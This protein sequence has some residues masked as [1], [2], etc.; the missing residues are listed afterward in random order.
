MTVLL[1][2]RHGST[3]AVGLRVSGRMP[4]VELNARGA[5]E[6]AALGA[7]LA[8]LPISVV[9]SSPIERAVATARAIA[10]PHRLE[11]ELRDGLSEIE[12]GEWTGLT[13][14]E[15]DQLPRWRAFNGFRAGTR[16]PAGEHMLEVQARMVREVERIVADHPTATVVLVSHGD[17]LKTLIG[18]F[19]G[20]PVDLWPRFDVSPASLSVLRVTTEGATLSL[21]NDSGASGATW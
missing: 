6:V 17:P 1:L 9:Y 21:L 11:V 10:T 18:H 12:F 13:F 4:G 16:P 14:D 15:L 7:R 20:I 19:L 3:D 8:A 5:D 2:V